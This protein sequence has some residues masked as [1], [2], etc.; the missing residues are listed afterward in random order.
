VHGS[1]YRAHQRRH[2]G[3]AL[4]ALAQSAIIAR[5]FERA[6][7]IV[8]HSHC[9]AVCAVQARDAVKC[10]QSGVRRRTPSGG[11]GGGCDGGGSRWSCWRGESVDSSSWTGRARRFHVAFR[12]AVVVIAV[13]GLTLLMRQCSGSVLA[14]L[15]ARLQLVP[16][17]SLLVVRRLIFLVAERESVVEA[18]VAQVGDAAGVLERRTRADGRQQVRGQR[19]HLLHVDCTA[20]Q[21]AALQLRKRAVASSTDTPC[22]RGYGR[23]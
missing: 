5:L 2:H 16:L 18:E 4:P 9:S 10:A 14:L 7:E 6:E 1:P 13:T 11:G 12:R 23:G 8:A 17:K 19:Q 3:C 20:H 22:C 21:I 15:L